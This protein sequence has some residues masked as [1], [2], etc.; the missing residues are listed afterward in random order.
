MVCC[1]IDVYTSS[2]P[3]NL[4]VENRATIIICLSNEFQQ[5]LGILRVAQVNPRDA[6]HHKIVLSECTLCL[7]RN[8]RSFEGPLIHPRP[9]GER[10][11]PDATGMVLDRA[12]PQHNIKERADPPLPPPSLSL[13]LSA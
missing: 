2:L 11:P 5:I 1:K 4:R 6:A 3:Q 12:R 13:S 10:N 8:C 7:A 9:K